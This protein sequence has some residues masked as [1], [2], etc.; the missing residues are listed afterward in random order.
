MLA[1]NKSEP[2]VSG[3]TEIVFKHGKLFSNADMILELIAE[4]ERENP[5]ITVHDE[6][7]PSNTDDQHRFF[8]INLEGESSDF[9]VFPLDVI[10]VPEF[11]R[12]GWVRPLD[13]LLT[14]EHRADLFS[15]TLDAVTFA[16][17]VNAIPWHVTAG[18]M[19][20]RSDLVP[21]PPKSWQE[22]S[23]VAL[24]VAKQ[25]PG[26][27]GFVWQG[28]Q[29]EGLVCDA[30]EYMWSFGGSVVDGTRSTI[31]SKQNRDALRFMR[32]LI[33][34]GVSPEFVLTLT[35][36]PSRRTFQDGRAVFHRNWPYAWRLLDA[37]G[38]TIRGNVGATVVPGSLATLGGWHIGINRYSRHPA[39]AEKFVRF[40]TGAHAMKKM[41]TTGEFHP[42]IRSLFRDPDLLA[43]DPNLATLVEIFENA[44]PR[45]VSPYYMMISQVLQI[46][47]SAI[48]SGIRS[49]EDALGS[50]DEQIGH[51]LEIEK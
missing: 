42:S 23:A 45:P 15:G 32:G 22:L 25:H 10:W 50:A 17:H 36:E 39:E 12:A 4:F 30:L 35:E 19:Y 6:E 21:T 5:G 14:E 40:M 20:Y 24:R 44:R 1:C 29:Y 48:L 3:R 18:L 34:R 33:E 51:I 49:P 11:A 38:S 2:T 7:L 46:E 47:I 31:D 27:H 16:G 9:D 41:T 13:H 37:P 26:M 8:A 28:K 43:Q